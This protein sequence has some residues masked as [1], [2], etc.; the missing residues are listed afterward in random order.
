MRRL[1]AQRAALEAEIAEISARE[2]RARRSEQTAARAA[3]RNWVLVDAVL[4]T[5]LIIHALTDGAVDPASR[6][7]AQAAAKRK[8][9]EKTA[10]ELD[11]LVLATFSSAPLDLLVGLTDEVEPADAEAMR[12][13]QTY[14]L[15]WRVVQWAIRLNSRKTPIA[16]SPDMVRMRWELERR[17]VPEGVRPPSRAGLSEKAVREWVRRWRA[18][19]DGKFGGLRLNTQPPLEEAVE[20]VCVFRLVR[21]SHS[22]QPFPDPRTRLRTS[23]PPLIL[24][25]GLFRVGAGSKFA[26][27]VSAHRL[28]SVPARRAQI[29]PAAVGSGP[30]RRA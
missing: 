2:K 22:G 15:E 23:C 16:P 25:S 1:A 5:V 8:W 18:R 12:S 10:E 21:P 9:S 27:A 7:L 29:K 6:Y 3:A 26:G 14:I 20:K 13:A 4:H 24:A 28:S 30:A 11:D 17:Q 19:W